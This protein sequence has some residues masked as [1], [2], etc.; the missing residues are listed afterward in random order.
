MTISTF[1]IGGLK[2]FVSKF[3]QLSGDEDTVLIQNYVDDGK[4]MVDFQFQR[5][6]GENNYDPISF[7][8]YFESISSDSVAR[9]FPIKDFLECLKKAE[10]KADLLEIGFE[11]STSISNPEEIA[12]ISTIFGD[13]TVVLGCFPIHTAENIKKDIRDE[14]LFPLTIESL[15]VKSSEDGEILYTS[16]Q[17]DWYLLFNLFELN[18]HEEA[19]LVLASFIAKYGAMPALETL[20]KEDKMGAVTRRARKKDTTVKNTSKDI[21]DTPAVT[22][23][24]IPVE[25]VDE[26]D[27][28]KKK[29]RSAEEILRDSLA[30]AKTLLETDGYTVFKDTVEESSVQVSVLDKAEL[31]RKLFKE[32]EVEVSAGE[33]TVNGV[34]DIT[35]DF[36]HDVTHLLNTA[37]HLEENAEQTTFSL[38]DLRNMSLVDF[39]KIR[40]GV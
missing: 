29:R 32:I 17:G 10:D 35:V 13:D 21:P 12:T 11:K 34:V 2:D 26:A 40:E 7:I 30:D 38:K 22:P 37:L 1:D 25:N 6:I 18:N 20:K 8:K 33:L 27:S 16:K 5:K 39:A 24:D 28:N 36:M 19:R 14:T 31:V 4:L 3:G 23:S 9:I 15:D